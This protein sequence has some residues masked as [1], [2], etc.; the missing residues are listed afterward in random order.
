MHYVGMKAQMCIC[1]WAEQ[2]I[3]KSLTFFVKTN[4]QIVKSYTAFES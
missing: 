2:E 1:P 4:Q 3:K